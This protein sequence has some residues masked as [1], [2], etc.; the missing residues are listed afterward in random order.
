MLSYYNK[1]I[2]YDHSDQC[3]LKRLN[4]LLTI[5]CLHFQVSRKIGKSEVEGFF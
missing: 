1:S 2:E 3:L 4:Q 5:I